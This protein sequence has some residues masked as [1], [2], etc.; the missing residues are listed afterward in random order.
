MNLHKSRKK[1]GMSYSLLLFFHNLLT[2]YVSKEIRFF[3]YK[4]PEIQLYT[5]DGFF[6]KSFFS[7]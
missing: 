5:G 6:K 3:F 7:G 2:L 4:I 1:L